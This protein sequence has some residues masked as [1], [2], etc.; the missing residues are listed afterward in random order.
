MSWLPFPAKSGKVGRS[1]GWG[2]ESRTATMEV[3]GAVHARRL[4]S[5]A[6]GHTPSGASRHLP[7]QAGE[8]I[9]LV[10]GRQDGRAAAIPSVHARLAPTRWI[11]RLAI[12]RTISSSAGCRSSLSGY[13]R[14]FAK[15][16]LAPPS[17]RSRGR[18]RGAPDGVWKA[19]LRQ[20]RFA[21]PFLQGVSRPRRRAK[22]HPALRATFPSK[23]GKGSRL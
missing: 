6:A 7:Q 19:G 12:F 16:E 20:W 3:C 13:A 9:A 5:T 22:P 10:V 18:W 4:S 21:A 2:L 14:R 1:A 11:S 23:L 15:R 17:P 8:G